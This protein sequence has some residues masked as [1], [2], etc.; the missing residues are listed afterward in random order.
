VD[1]VT[2]QDP[3][4]KVS[5]L[6]THGKIALVND[7]AQQGKLLAILTKIDLLTYL[8]AKV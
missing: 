2:P 6:L 8:G 5:K 3:L 7:P 1:Y 4:E